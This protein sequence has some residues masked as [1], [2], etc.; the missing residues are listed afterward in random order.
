VVFY[1]AGQAAALPLE[2]VERI[3]PM[4]HLARP[5]GLPAALEGILNLGGRAVP[6]LR[7]DRL[8]GLP[9][10]RP[11]LYS[12]LILLKDIASTRV[13]LLVDRVSD[14]LSVPEGDR[15]PVAEQHSFNGCATAI[16]PAR[17]AAIHLLSGARI[18]LEQERASLAEFQTIAQR[19]IE[20]WSIEKQ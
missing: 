11:G 14:I 16:I 4:A 13:G 15:L 17:G 1:L 7:L 18:L 10:E 20:E 2:E 19:R 9:L 3:I 5:H 6:V 12:L 8:L